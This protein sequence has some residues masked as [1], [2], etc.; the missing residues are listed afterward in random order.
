M[1]EYWLASHAN[2]IEAYNGYRRTCKPTGMQLS[3]EASPGAFPRSFWYPAS[4]VNR[5]ENVEQKGNVEGKVFWDA[6]PAGCTLQ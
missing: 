3:L 1:K 2:G 6:N 5:N 4:F